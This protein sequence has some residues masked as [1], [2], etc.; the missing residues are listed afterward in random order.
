M[1]Y[2][3]A[4]DLLTR[5][6]V[7][8]ITQRAAREVPRLVTVDMLRIAAEGGDLTGYTDDV[9]AAIAKAMDKI[10]AALSDAHNLIDSY[11]AGRFALPLSPVPQVL[12]RIACELARYYLYDDQLTDPVKQRYEGNIK[13]LRDVSTGTVRLG[14][15]AD[16]GAAPAGTGNAELVSA[17]RIW[18]RQASK[19][20]L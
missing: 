15:D 12:P 10:E 19:G 11:L 3:T 16:S 6:D 9:R 1:T 7:D 14:V 4:Q 20:F 5:F 13:F 18:D 8:E 2:A 17:G